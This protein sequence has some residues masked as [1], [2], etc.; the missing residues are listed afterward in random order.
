M[1]ALQ[2]ALQRGQPDI[3]NTDQGSQFTSLAFTSVLEAAAIRISMDGKG[4]ALDNIFVERLWR[5]VKYEDLYLNLYAT[6][7]ALYAGFT[8]TFGFTTRNGHTK[9]WKTV[10][11]LPFTKRL[12]GKGT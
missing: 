4:R 7:P 3:F 8:H 11:Q 2:Q 5:T 6:V 9:V 1:E 10:R 12:A